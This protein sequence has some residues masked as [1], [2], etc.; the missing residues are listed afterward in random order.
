MWKRKAGPV[1]DLQTALAHH[2]AGR[3]DDAERLYDKILRK[4]PGNADALLL[5]GQL[6][7]ARGDWPRSLGYLDRAVT[8]RPRFAAALNARGAALIAVGRR[9]DALADLDAAVAAM[10]TMAEAW[11]N[12]GN[13]LRSAGQNDDAVASYDKALDIRPNYASALINRGATLLSLNRPADALASSA[14]LLADTPGHA[15]A[16]VLSS[17]ALQALK[18]ED[19]SIERLRRALASHP[20]HAEALTALGTKLLARG[21]AQESLS[22]YD[23]ALAAAPGSQAARVG[24]GRVLFALGRVA[25]ATAALR[26]ATAQMSANAEAWSY[27]GFLLLQQQQHTEALS[28]CQ[29]AL[30]LKPKLPDAL[31]HRAIALQQLHR[32]P[33]SAAAY[34]EALKVTPDRLELLF[35]YGL[36]LQFTRHAEES[37]TVF[38]RVAALQPDHEHIAGFAVAAQ[39]Q[40][41]DWNDLETR[42]AEITEG[43]SAGR[44][45]AT[46]FQFLAMSQSA[47]LHLRCGRT[48]LDRKYPAARH[49]PWRPGRHAGRAG[50]EKIRLAYVSADFRNH[51]TTHLVTE[52]IELH[53]RARFEVIGVSIGPGDDTDA[54]RRIRSAFDH[55]V[56]VAGLSDVRAAEALHDLGADI[57]IDL[58]GHT[59]LARFDLLLKR[60]APIQVQYIG[61]PVFGAPCMDYLIVDHFVVP[62]D[63]EALLPD[64]LVFLPHTMQP[65]DRRRPIALRAP[66]RGQAGLP[67]QGFVFSCFNNAYKI[68]P[69][70][71]DVW[72]RLLHQVEDSVLWLLDDNAAVARNLRNQAAVRGIAPERLIFA[73]RAALADHLARHALADL[74]V[75]TLPVNACTTASDA[76]WAGLP[77]VTCAGESFT[78]RMAGSLLHA[79]GLPD[80][81]TDSLEAYEALCLRLARS[82][83]ALA[84]IRRRV[85]SA[86]DASPLFDSKLYCHHIETAYARMWERHD[87]GEPPH[88]FSVP[89]FG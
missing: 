24:R 45:V 48:E 56:D 67:E 26:A 17:A 54:C 11:F 57:A 53:D 9:A 50:S 69:Q 83:D 59:A 27:L 87:A 43:V 12:R 7:A 62:S 38:R 42:I 16:L 25:E 18:R 76:L 63:Q 20:G 23:R 49:A 15:E 4:Q 75:D 35:N 72:M 6:H 78:A 44:R 13:A 70:I 66:S 84:D 86:R 85:T 19:E 47:A 1:E 81:V 80:L 3:L 41:C 51:A 71:F 65:N 29:R 60:P 37:A 34:A 33:E 68:T 52:L 58:M 39:M 77:V 46:P 2:Q 82:S 5:A 22:L 88:G 40:A 30:T 64:N 73:P 14:R 61:H 32:W 55:H 74:F 28:C 31:T 36:L 8:A 89:A 10:P 79:A 21:E